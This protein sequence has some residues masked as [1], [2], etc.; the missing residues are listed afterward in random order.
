MSD[1]TK[2]ITEKIG[3]NKN[4]KWQLNDQ[5][6]LNKILEEIRNAPKLKFPD[7]IK[8]FVLETDAS[9]TAL[10]GVLKQENKYIGF[11]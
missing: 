8:T 5:D 7:P 3:K 6:K 11:F 9:S 1:K 10:G 2:F 4:W